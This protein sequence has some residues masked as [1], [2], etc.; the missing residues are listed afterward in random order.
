MIER[1]RALLKRLATVNLGLGE[2]VLRM[3]AREQDGELDPEDLR[4]VG[5]PL[6]QLGIDMLARAGEIDY[7]LIEGT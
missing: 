2:V 6:R 1:D 4:A 5:E 7:P 3:L